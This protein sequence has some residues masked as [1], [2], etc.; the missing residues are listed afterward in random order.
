MRLIPV[1]SA[2]KIIRKAGGSRASDNAKIALKNI[3]EEKAEEVGKKAASL[4][5]H[6]GRK[7]IKLQDIKLAVE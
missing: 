6:A 3:L 7:T 4:A 2:E 5:R 1:A